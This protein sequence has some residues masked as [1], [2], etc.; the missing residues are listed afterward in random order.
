MAETKGGDA[1]SQQTLRGAHNSLTIILLSSSAP[2]PKSCSWLSKDTMG[3]AIIFRIW[4]VLG[5]CLC[6]LWMSECGEWWLR[7][8]SAVKML[9]VWRSLPSVVQSLLCLVKSFAKQ[10]VNISKCSYSQT[11][12]AHQ[13]ANV[14][15]AHLYQ[16]RTKSLSNHKSHFSWLSPCVSDIPPQAQN[17]ATGRALTPERTASSCRES[18]FN[19]AATQSISFKGICKA[20]AHQPL[21]SP[22]DGN[23]LPTI[24]PPHLIVSPHRQYAHQHRQK[25]LVSMYVF[26]M[27]KWI[28]RYQFIWHTEEMLCCR[29]QNWAHF[30]ITCDVG[31][32]REAVGRMP[33]D[34]PSGHYWMCK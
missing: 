31:H 10:L 26:D 6:S 27:W 33:F 23:W 16:M 28:S 11:I 29:I 25:H 34:R 18:L 12:E 7:W 14:D 22:T 8:Q 15:M 17:T 19:Y 32:G 13:W 3:N 2:A 24:I 20:A 9:W 5:V 4:W 1:C 21:L 30:L